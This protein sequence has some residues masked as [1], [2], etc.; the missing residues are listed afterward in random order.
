MDLPELYGNRACLDFAN[1]VEPRRDDPAVPLREYLHG[2]ADLVIWAGYAGVLG[3]GEAEQLLAAAAARPDEA[4]AA[5]TRAIALREAIYRVF[6]AIA[7]GG[8]PPAGDLDEVQHAYAEAMA[9]ARI[10]P[11]A[12]GLDGAAGREGA[13]R[14]DAG[15]R[16]R[17]GHGGHL[18]W[19]WVGGRE[20]DRP[21][22]PLARSAVELL[23]GGPL[24]RVK[25]CPAPCGWLF[26]DVTRNGSRHWCSMSECGNQ[27]KSRR[28]SARRRAARAAAPRRPAGG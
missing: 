16:H 11:A 25:S 4:E 15:H 5:F 14:E 21:L 13:G 24:D 19:T 28:L 2:Y 3:D 18:D 8:E 12:A 23:V 17:A 22:W 10:R 7:D 27:A 26:L 20:L 9:A 1:S 6:A